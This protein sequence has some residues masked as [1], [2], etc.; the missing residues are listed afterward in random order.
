MNVLVGKEHYSVLFHLRE[1]DVSNAVGLNSCE[2]VLEGADKADFQVGVVPKLLR[3]LHD[4]L[5]HRSL[6]ISLC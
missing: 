5:H 1:K 2:K 6:N 3:R 4:Q